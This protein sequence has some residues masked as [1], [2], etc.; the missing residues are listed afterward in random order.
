MTVTPSTTE[1]TVTRHIR[2]PRA[3]VFAAWTSTEMIRRWF[4]PGDTPPALIEADVRVGGQYRIEFSGT[5][6]EGK[7]GM[8]VTGRYT[9]LVP[10]RRLQFTWLPTDTAQESLVTVEVADVGD[11]TE[12]RLTHTGL[13][14][15][16]DVAR[17]AHG[18]NSILDK[19]AANYGSVVEIAA[20][21]EKVYAALSSLPGLRGWWTEV[22]GDTG[23]GGEIVFTFGGRGATRMRIEA[24]D[25]PRGGQARVHWL[26]L[27]S[28]AVADWKGTRVE[29]ALSPGANGSTQL[30]FEHL[31]LVPA[32][33]CFEDCQKGWNKYLPSL[34]AYAETGA[35]YPYPGR[36]PA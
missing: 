13:A 12:L 6:C 23:V 36:K 5:S 25:A 22:A 3:V 18:W 16:A 15:A 26:C 2:A 4:I 24:T 33:A 32:L 8:G 21:P 29:F 34:K 9:E 11:G 17:H 35:G 19:F 31:G 20:A 14:D 1:L 10:N 28:E 7:P 27:G 30:R